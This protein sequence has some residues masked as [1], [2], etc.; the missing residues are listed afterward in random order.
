MRL[1]AL[2]ETRSPLTNALTG[3]VVFRLAGCAIERGR[4]GVEQWE[5]ERLGMQCVAMSDTAQAPGHLFNERLNPLP[6]EGEFDSWI[7]ER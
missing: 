7:E 1:F 4:D 3:M 5:V 2:S 6:A